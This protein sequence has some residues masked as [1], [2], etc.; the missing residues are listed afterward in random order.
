MYMTG[1]VTT[2]I[3]AI[4]SHAYPGR[5]YI[6]I[7][8]QTIGM[9]VES[10]NGP[11]SKLSEYPKQR[12]RDENQNSILLDA[13]P[14]NM[15]AEKVF[16]YG[17]GGIIGAC[18]LICVPAH[19]VAENRSSTAYYVEGWIWLSILAFGITYQ[20][21]SAKLENRILSPSFYITAILFLGALSTVSFIQGAMNENYLIQS[22]DNYRDLYYSNIGINVLLLASAIAGIFLTACML[23]FFDVDSRLSE[24]GQRLHLFTAARFDN[25]IVGVKNSF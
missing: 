4:T 16:W 10:V 7:N 8:A 20:T 24:R 13:K 14:S 25:Y 21:V 18:L 12:I 23:D 15:S 17:L 3:C 22:N 5:P 11:P 2:Y 9:S 19:V 6:P 1:I